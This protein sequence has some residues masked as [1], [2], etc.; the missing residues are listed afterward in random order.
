[1]VELGLSAV[2]MSQCRGEEGKT[3][4]L[5]QAASMFLSPLHNSGSAECLINVSW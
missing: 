4:F 5:T 2:K 1:M 3:G